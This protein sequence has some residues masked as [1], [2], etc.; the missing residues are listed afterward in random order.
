MS[1]VFSV[2]AGLTRNPLMVVFFFLPLSLPAQTDTLR[3][4]LH[5]VIRLAQLQSVDAAVALN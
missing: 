4:T 2:I 1:S 5:D 3:M